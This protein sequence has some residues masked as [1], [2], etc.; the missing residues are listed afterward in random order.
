MAE[1][2]NKIEEAPKRKRRTKAEIE[3]AKKNGTYKPRKKTAKVEEQAEKENA[4]EQ[5]KKD[6]KPEQS[7]LIMSCLNP[8]V[9]KVA[10]D[11]AK[12]EGVQVVIL[13]DKVI[14][15][16]LDRSQ[17]A[18]D[19]SEFLSNTSNRLKAESDARRLYAMLTNG[20]NVEDSTGVVF[21]TTQIVKRTNL[22]HSKAAS[23]LELFRAFG[24]IRL[25]KGVHEFEFTF[26]HEFRRNSI[27]DEI[28]G[29]LKVTNTDIQ[30]F[31]ASI[32]NDDSLTSEQKDKMYK[33]FQD[34]FN[35]FLEF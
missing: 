34:S 30:R 27:R 29:M 8:T 17:K 25:V 26:S 6:L 14:Y 16:Y 3:E 11:A 28:F 33:D 21:T 4:V 12:K 31:R 20:G 35:E 32:Y 15:D 22:S 23:L 2:E 9:A 18:Q 1:L 5:K 24:L 10:C 7:V 13:E 19:L